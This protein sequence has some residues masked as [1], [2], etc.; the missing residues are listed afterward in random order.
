MLTKIADKINDKDFISQAVD[1]FYSKIENDP[2]ISQF[3]NCTDMKQQ[4][5]MQTSFMIYILG[6][7]EAYKGKGLNKIHKDM[8]I[9][10]KHF[11]RV[12]HHILIT[13]AELNIDH[14][15]VNKIS[16]ILETTKSSIVTIDQ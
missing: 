13:L 10:P 1:I 16:N 12:K 4:K 8:K 7:K 6:G 9:T 2:Q 14:E 15:H 5:K 11:E 3:F